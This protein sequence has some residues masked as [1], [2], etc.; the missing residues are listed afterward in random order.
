MR[1]LR[2]V[3]HGTPASQGSKQGF[4]RGKKVVLVEMDKELPEWRAAVEAAARLAAGPGWE[5]IDTA[6]KVQGE[7]R[8]RKPASTKFQDHPAGPKDL[9]KIL[10]GVGD[11]LEAAKIVTNDARICHWDVRKVWADGMPGLDIEI[12]EL[13]GKA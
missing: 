12:I 11:S 3:V 7:I 2:I 10:R 1:R 13:G 9:D 8:I 4:I 5:P 6:V